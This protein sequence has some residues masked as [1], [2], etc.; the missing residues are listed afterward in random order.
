M[1]KFVGVVLAGGASRRMQ[2]DKA[3]IDVAGRPMLSWVIDALES[4]TEEI[5]V[6]GPERPGWDDRRH[7]P[8]TGSPH[9][10]PLAGVVAVMEQVDPDAVL[11]VV[12]VDQPWIRVRT[13]Q[14]IVGRFAQRPV[15]PVPDGVRQTTCAAYPA[16]LSLVAMREL[17]A[18]GSIQSML[19]RTAFD[20]FTEADVAACGEDGRSWFSVNTP[21]DLADGLIRYGAPT[22]R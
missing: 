20:P 16:D 2:T 17:N 10:G 7:V 12:G 1:T 21:D 4:V 13:L 9:R 11:V 19:D 6:A 18:G 22:Y 8:D 15:V 14:A 3:V 5:V